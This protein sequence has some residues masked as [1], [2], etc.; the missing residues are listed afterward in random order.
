MRKAAFYRCLKNEEDGRVFAAKTTGFSDG[1]IGIHKAGDYWFATYI[2]VGC[3]ITPILS[4]KKTPAAALKEAKNII[5]EN[6]DFEARIQEMMN[7]DSYQA[8]SQSRYKQECF[9]V[10]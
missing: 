10:L 4:H 3:K 5:A 6:P 8:F 9:T 1:D 2:P 7:D